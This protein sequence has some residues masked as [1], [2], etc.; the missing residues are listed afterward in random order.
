MSNNY[1]N[2]RRTRN[3]TFI[4]TSSPLAEPPRLLTAPPPTSVAPPPTSTKPL[5][6]SSANSITPV[7]TIRG[8]WYRFDNT[9]FLTLLRLVSSVYTFV[10]R[11]CQKDSFFDGGMTN[12]FENISAST[13]N[14]AIRP[15]KKIL[16]DPYMCLIPKMREMGKGGCKP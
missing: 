11:W 15:P 16:I 13:F 7:R 3:L 9:G 14:S 2:S 1:S 8:M 12:G 4:I 5:H 6:P 10:S